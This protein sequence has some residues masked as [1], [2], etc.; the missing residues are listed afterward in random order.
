M[1]EGNTSA[2]D[3]VVLGLQIFLLLCFYMFALGVFTF[4]GFA[5]YRSVAN[6]DHPVHAVIMSSVITFAFLILTSV[7]TMVFT[8]I[9]KEGHKEVPENGGSNHESK[10]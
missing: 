6:N 1:K 7:V 4:L 3:K 2:R 9:I 5:V 10:I 8:A